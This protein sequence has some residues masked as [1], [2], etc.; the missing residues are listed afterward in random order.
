[1]VSIPNRDLGFFPRFHGETSC[2]GFLV[3]I[4]NRDLGFFPLKKPV[5]D[6]PILWCFNP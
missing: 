3:S 2:K 5:E 6:E 1:M 4:P